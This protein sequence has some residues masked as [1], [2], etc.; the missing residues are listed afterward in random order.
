MENFK[1]E[2][3]LKILKI[4]Y[5]SSGSVTVTLRKLTPIFG[6]RN[7]PNKTTI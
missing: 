2:Q 4:Y 3:R 6:H 7:H 1:L 5:E